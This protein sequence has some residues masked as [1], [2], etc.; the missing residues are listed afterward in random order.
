MK[1]SLLF[2]ILLSFCFALRTF[3]QCTGVTITQQPSS[4]TD[5][6]GKT[7]VFKVNLAGTA[8]FTY[9][10]YSYKSWDHFSDP[11]GY[12]EYSTND[13]IFSISNVSPDDS[14]NYYGCY[15][16]NCSGGYVYSD[17][18]PLNVI[19]YNCSCI[20]PRILLQPRDTNVNASALY[21]L[22]LSVKVNIPSATVTWYTTAYSDG[23][24]WDSTYYV[25]YPEKGI[26]TYD[27]PA[28]SGYALWFSNTLDYTTRNY[29]VIKTCGGTIT[30][31]TVIVRA[32]RGGGLQSNLA[33]SDTINSGASVL[34]GIT[35]YANSVDYTDP[36]QITYQWYK[37]DTLI[38]GATSDNYQTPKLYPSDSA[39][40]FYC[41]VSGCDNFWSATSNK[42]TIVVKDCSPF[43][44]NFFNKNATICSGSGIS[45]GKTATTGH[46]YSWISSPAGF[47]STS[48]NPTVNPTVTTVYYLSDKNNSCG[49]TKLD[50]FN[51]TV[52]PTPAVGN[53]PWR[54][55]ST[56]IGWNLAYSIKSDGTLWGWGTAVNSE[57]GSSIQAQTISYP[58]QI[59]ISAV[60]STYKQDW[61]M[62]SA[63]SRYGLAINYDSSL[64]GWG[65]NGSGNV[66]GNPS[67]YP[68]YYSIDLIDNSSKWIFAQ[69][70]GSSSYGIKKDGTLW[71]W[72]DNYYGQ[73]G[74]GSSVSSEY[75]PTQVDSSHWSALAAGPDYVLAIKNN[76]T[77]WAWGNNTKGS[78]GDKSTA[79][80][81]L[82]RQVGTDSDWVTVAAAEYTSSA[83]KADG[84]LWVWGSNDNGQLGI[85]SNATYSDTLVKVPGLWKYCTP[86][87]AIK[88][89]GTLWACGAGYESTYRMLDPTSDWVSCRR[90]AASFGKSGGNGTRKDGSIW[91]WGDNSNGIFGDS[92]TTSS[93][94]PVVLGQAAFRNSGTIC[95]GTSFNIG[96][97]SINTYSYSWTSKP[98]GFTSTIANPDFSP[99]ITTTYYLNVTS[100]GCQNSD[101][102]VIKVLPLTGVNAGRDTAIC[103]GDTIV[104]GNS[105]ISGAAYS[106]TSK[107]AGFTSTN[108]KP[109]VTPSV[110][111][112]YYL[113]LTDSMGCQGMDSML[114]SVS[115][116]SAF[117]GN[118]TTVCAGTNIKI[119][120]SA[121]S[122]HSYSWSSNPAGFSD[123]TANPAIK[124]TLNTTYTI[125]DKL[126]SSGCVA[127]DSVVITANSLPA[128]YT[129][130]GSS[131]CPG[132]NNTYTIGSSSPVS[133]NSYTW[134]SKPSGYNW[135]SSSLQVTP[136]VTT[137]F[138]LTETNNATGCSK[139]DSVTISMYPIPAAN[140][141]KDTTVCSGTTVK[142]GAPAVNGHT[143]SWDFGPTSSNP[144]ISPTTTTTYTLSEKDTITG[145]SNSNAVVVTN[146][147]LPSVNTGG[148]KSICI[149]SSTI[150]GP[151]SSTSGHTYSW[152][153]SP[154]GFTS[155]SFNPTVSPA[156]TTTYTLIEKI[157]GTGCID[158]NTATVTVNP[159]PSAVNAGRD[160]TVC[161]GAA[162]TIGSSVVLGY[163]YSWTSNPPGFTS[164]SSN[165]IISPT[166]KA[167]Y[168]VTKTSASTGCSIS[169]SVVVSINPLPAVNAGKDTTICSGDSISVG[170][171]SI[172]GD[173]YS[174]SSSP[175]GFSSSMSNPKLTAIA[176]TYTFSTFI[177]KETI[178]ATGCSNSDSMVVNINTLPTPNAGNDTTICAGLQAKIGV[179]P[180]FGF[181]NSW[182]AISSGFTSTNSPE[183][184][185][186]P[187]TTTYVFTQK[188]YYSGCKQNDTVV[189]NVT[190]APHTRSGN[191]TSIC[192]GLAATLG[193]A[194]T[195]GHKYS[196]A[197]D[198]AGFTS[199]SSSAIVSPKLTTT[200]YLTDTSKATGCYGMDTVTVTVNPLPVPN[201]GSSKTVCPGYS[202]TIGSSPVSGHVYSWSSN[203]AGYSSTSSNPSAS[204]YVT[205]KY[206]INDKLTSTGCSNTDS[207]TINLTH[208]PRAKT[209]T[210][211]NGTTTSI[212]LSSIA[213][214]TYSW[215][216]NPPGF[217]STVSN[218]GVSPSVTTT[219]KLNAYDS[220]FSCAYTDSAII[221][222]NPL[223]KV[224]AGTNTHICSGSAAIGDSF[225]TGHKYA[226]SSIPWGYSSTASNNVVAPYETTRYILKE[227]ISSTGCSDTS[228]VLVTHNPLTISIAYA[229]GY[230][231]AGD[232]F[233]YISNV[234]GDSPY[235]F[236]WYLNDVPVSGA[237]SSTY[238]NPG[239]LDLGRYLIYCIVKN[240]SNN[241]YAKS[242]ERYL[243]VN[244]RRPRIEIQPFLSK[245]TVTECEL[246]TARLKT[247]NAEGYSYNWFDDNNNDLPGS[248]TFCTFNA[249]HTTSISC[250]IINSCGETYS[251]KS[252]SL[253]VLPG[254]RP[255]VSHI[256][257]QPKSQIFATDGYSAT[258][259][260]KL[261][262]NDPSFKYQWYCLADGFYGHFY[263]PVQGAN[264]DSFVTAPYDFPET[265]EKSYNS[266]YLFE[267]KYFC[268]IS[269]SCGSFSISSDT[270]SV[271][272][273]PN[274][275]I[276]QQPS[277][278][279]VYLCGSSTFQVKVRRGVV[280]WYKN[281]I[282][283]SGATSLSYT[284]PSV[285]ISDTGDVYFC[286]NTL[287]GYPGVVDTSWRVRVNLFINVITSQ[288]SAAVPL[289]GRLRISTA[290]SSILVDSLFWYYN[291]KVI[292][293]YGTSFVWDDTISSPTRVLISPDTNNYYYCE[294]YTCQGMLRS[295][296]AYV[297]LLQC[298]Y[299]GYGVG[300]IKMTPSGDI[301]S[302]AS[303]VIQLTAESEE[304]GSFKWY[305]TTFDHKNYYSGIDIY[306]TPELV[307]E[308]DSAYGSELLITTD[309]Y[310]KDASNKIRYYFTFSSCA[311]S[312][313]SDPLNI[314][315][316]PCLYFTKTPQTVYASD[317]WLSNSPTNFNNAVKGPM[318]FSA[319][320]ALNNSGG[321]IHYKWY[322]YDQTIG[323]TD[324]ITDDNTFSG[325]LTST[326]T[327]Q[328]NTDFF[329]SQ[330]Y[331]VISS[332]SC[333]Q[334]E[335]SKSAWYG[336]PSHLPMD[337]G[338]YYDGSAYAGSYLHNYYV[339]YGSFLK[340][341][342]KA[343][344]GGAYINT[345]KT[346][347]DPI[348]SGT[349]IYLCTHNDFSL[350]TPSGDLKFSRAYNSND[351]DLNGSMGHGWHHNFDFRVINNDTLWN[352]QYPDGHAAF[353][354]PVFDSTGFSV[355]VF[356]Q[357]ND[358][359][360]QNDK[361]SAFP[362]GFTL[363]TNEKSRILF[364]SF[365]LPRIIEDRNHNLINYTYDSA[366]NII[367]IGDK[368][369]RSINFVY[370]QSFPVNKLIQAILPSGKSYYYTY[371]SDN[372]HSFID[373]NGYTVIYDYD[374]A[375]LLTAV[376]NASGDTV[377][378]NTYDTL[379]RVVKQKDAYNQQ[380]LLNY[381]F[382]STGREVTIT[383]PNGTKNEV[384]FDSSMCTRKS[385]DELKRASYFKFD[386]FGKLDSVLGTGNQVETRKYDSGGN[387]TS[388]TQ[389]G[390]GKISCN[391][392]ATCQPIK[393][394][395]ARGNTTILKYD[396][397]DNPVSFIFA[398]STRRTLSYY[399]NGKIKSAED[400]NGNITSYFYDSS[401]N[402]TKVSSPHG[403][404]VFTYDADGKMLSAMN[405][406][407]NEVDMSYDNNGNLATVTDPLGQETFY[408]Y[409]AQNQMSLQMDRRGLITRLVYD[410]LGRITARIN[411]YSYTD[412]FFYDSRNNIVKLKDANDN[413]IEYFYD[414]GNR[415]IGKK[416]IYGT[417]KYIYDS[418]GNLIQTIDPTNIA[419]NYTYNSANRLASVTDASGNTGTYKYDSVGNIIASID[420]MGKTTRFTYDK[421][422]R[423]STLVDAENNTTLYEYNGNGALKS[424]IDPN[425]H[426]LQFGYNNMNKINEINDAESTQYKYE[427]DSTGNITKII[428]PGGIIANTFD[429]LNRKTRVDMSSGEEYIYSYD[430]DN[431]IISM[432]NMIV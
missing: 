52:N 69:A 421:L 416:T 36:D 309:E 39:V 312:S 359:L 256:S 305:K 160:T 170:S 314:E 364:D 265:L 352:L 176:S 236:Q 396:S 323:G 56:S 15:I 28:Q 316:Q 137:T 152:V 197:S 424:I 9:T 327:I 113:S 203:P 193:A 350:T 307:A 30:S 55:I 391:Y 417:I 384:F 126:K 178:T 402:L 408:E 361:Y 248:D 215:T 173:T 385:I 88:T 91:F 233:T 202:A 133:G 245:D 302:G 93:S 121:K 118:D 329:G 108:A 200:Y 241:V 386:V 243:R 299:S 336:F 41:Y 96:L 373:A 290:C 282:A 180:V 115:V 148:G 338:A 343:Y 340:N 53:V 60:Y 399:P 157:T 317:G 131:E 20:Q 415:M 375:H 16:T 123:T 257:V 119:G 43:T 412:S 76:G 382:D 141:G 7:V 72:G 313:T 330:F 346:V 66:H 253:T 226:W 98:S 25:D 192:L 354:S 106:W 99:T 10:W 356:A 74:L 360:F 372:L 328:Y 366:H 378:K 142:I 38:S 222:V 225:K 130:S 221:N 102:L 190:P 219:Y 284:I 62:V 293:K 294:I 45:I 181:T 86:G 298:P 405:E 218:P 279:Y 278:Q 370:D 259:N 300:N 172:S 97:P 228:S 12:A 195:S 379:N 84:S 403:E 23:V 167:T 19:K 229:S 100:G 146:N 187:T 342:L 27:L 406:R 431:N 325:V 217:T 26:S 223:P 40:N 159:L 65:H 158:S 128:A 351:H 5:T 101:S 274:T 397:N 184:V 263:A 2:A 271:T 249:T 32:C 289:G 109:V 244:C 414:D 75:I 362:K 73:L 139:T 122:G 174:W 357:T 206:Y 6:C 252:P 258:F 237:T 275:K 186:P 301:T 254:T 273:A 334:Y 204:P 230:L 251:W 31:D 214:N 281:G 70:A 371:D 267:N 111:T 54:S 199:T 205:T 392:N 335:I 22:N 422:N 247:D 151:S 107:P 194:S 79:I 413:Q 212:G 48:S 4:V 145:C 367:A 349:G 171:P 303:S 400:G 177:L 169:D 147:P 51:I 426:R 47:S 87:F 185:S 286:V 242:N 135:F 58:V 24:V 355:P 266:N 401:G 341:P 140:A 136:S 430:E 104:I 333:S 368:E 42:E 234:T 389:T 260:F 50:T 374:T 198:P 262:K 46:K 239:N 1:R 208:V 94:V 322:R 304:Q 59:P 83:I 11:I 129:G 14:G 77:L 240:C 324:S 213:L 306:S 419:T 182:H 207:V 132:S 376:I 339:N 264:S 116:P 409:N 358:R 246:V 175:T 67:F 103:K 112:M 92:N 17:E 164:T 68:E 270:V 114:V 395:D 166:K 156:S 13:S 49:L 209:Y 64:W 134:T 283:I 153:S 127:K 288:P 423:L 311:G 235:V 287:P 82:P 398:D 348:E 310:I 432:S 429:A 377:I 189:V 89:D 365:G 345:Q 8:P 210:V 150:L 326:L 110:T 143:Y 353:F 285:H 261:N 125:T 238:T 161:F 191:D 280:Q 44:E 57:L 404:K 390:G 337:N 18:V 308:V 380:T 383:A 124:P 149:G 418:I 393:I 296:N 297:H 165:P 292:K 276:T 387:I 179:S 120:A 71:A 90:S 163:N 227:T 250:H 407:G 331:C 411:P 291:G 21:D 332:P 232:D 394:T 363:N 321:T 220:T 154:S 78:R 272:V 315:V 216:S 425:Q 33:L 80:A 81:Y 155:T 255:E 63:G 269:N 381:Q 231:E 224:N 268:K 105:V 117:A 319:D 144:S 295:K 277:S 37:N 35:A 420:A 138:Y 318:T 34:L 427:Y 95:P 85:G 196:W 369:G 347:A 320:A 61:K 410:K 344:V 211:C 388:F 183:Y 168:T 201:A 188:N 162:N 428:K 3:G 29:C